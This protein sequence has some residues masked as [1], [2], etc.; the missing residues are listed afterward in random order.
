MNGGCE[1]AYTD[2]DFRWLIYFSHE[3]TVTFAG[4]F[5][6]QVKNILRNETAHW[7]RWG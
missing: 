3:G 4:S 2:K 5:V 7:N 6:P 1:V